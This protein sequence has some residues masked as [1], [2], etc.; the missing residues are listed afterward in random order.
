MSYPRRLQNTHNRS[1]NDRGT[2]DFRLSLS[3]DGSTFTEI[4]D[5]TMNSVWGTGSAIPIESYS[6]ANLAAR[7][8]RFNL[9]KLFIKF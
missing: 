4:V 3:T 5:A 1:Y 2:E 7:Y 6:V 8:V 9:D